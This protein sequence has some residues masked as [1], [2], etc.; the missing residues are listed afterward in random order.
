M[1]VVGS[2]RETVRELI[3]FL[4]FVSRC[5]ICISVSGLVNVSPPGVSVVL[6][7]IDD[8]T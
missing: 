2:R 8:I 1:Q 5:D 6:P 3:T 4:T 7:V